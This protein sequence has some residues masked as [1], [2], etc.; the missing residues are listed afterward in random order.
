MDCATDFFVVWFEFVQI[1]HLLVVGHEHH[2]V[3]RIL[4]VLGHQLFL[5][6]RAAL[7]DE[8]EGHLFRGS[9]I[10]LGLLV[11]LVNEEF[12]VTQALKVA[13]VLEHHVH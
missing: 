13:S 2:G 10:E 1:F 4:E 9:V 12:G 8:V 6:M 3:D 5:D 7:V 11:L